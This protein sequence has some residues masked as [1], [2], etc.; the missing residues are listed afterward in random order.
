MSS[1][2]STKA[3]QMTR[4][5]A[6][7]ETIRLGERFH[8]LSESGTSKA[9]STLTAHDNVLVSALDEVTESGWPQNWQRKTTAKPP[10]GIIGLLGKTDRGRL[11]RGKAARRRAV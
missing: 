2:A 8:H 9:Y 5:V 7:S 11:S 6:A 3:R 4:F 1:S 10:R